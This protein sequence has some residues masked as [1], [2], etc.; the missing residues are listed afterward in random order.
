MKTSYRF[1][2]NSDAFTGENYLL[3]QKFI[4]SEGKTRK[5]FFASRRGGRTTTPIIFSARTALSPFFFAFFVEKENLR[6][7]KTSAAGRSK[8]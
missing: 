6:R 7:M 5:K 4:I 3:F 1:T 8:R 2:Q